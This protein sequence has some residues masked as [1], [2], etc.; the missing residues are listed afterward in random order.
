MRHILRI[1]LWMLVCLSFVAVQAQDKV[2]T[3]KVTSSEDGAGLPGVSITVK[4]TT[5]GANS[6]VE[7]NYRISIPDNATLVFSFVGFS[8]L[9][10]KVNGRSVINVQLAQDTKTLSE[11]VVTGFGSQIKRELTGNIAQVRERH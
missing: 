3:G 6:D 2:V 8:P 10:E 4:G 7:G 5:R 11:I 1:S 9:E